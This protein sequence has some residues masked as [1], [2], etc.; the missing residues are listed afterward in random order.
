MSDVMPS[1]PALVRQQAERLPAKE[2]II[3]GDRRV[4]Y[5]ELERGM[6]ETAAAMVAHGVQPGDRVAIWAP[7]SIDWLLAGLGALATGASIVP[8]SSRYRGGEA[9]DIITRSS[10]KLVLTS[11]AFR[12]LDYPTMLRTECPHLDRVPLVLLAGESSA[13][14][15]L[16][17]QDFLADGG[18]HV[19]EVNARIDALHP[20]D[21]AY[22]LFTSGTTGRP[23]GAL[24]AH[25][26]NLMCA[27]NLSTYWPVTEDDRMYVALPFFHIFGLNGGFLTC[28]TAGATCVIASVFE[29]ETTLQ[30]MERER[31]TFVPGP[32]TIFQG[33]LDHPDRSNYDLSSLKRGFV[34]ST[35]VSETLLRRMLD[36]G[37]VTAIGTGYGLTEAGGTVTLSPPDDDPEITARWSGKILPTVE[38]RIVDD[39]GRDLSNGQEGEILVRSRQVMH[40]YLD[41][42]EATALAID[43]DGW[44]HTGDV[45]SVNDDGY[46]KVTDRKKDMFIV[47][48]FNAYPAEIE[49]IL[50]RHSHVKSVAVVG[51]PDERL[52]EVGVAFVIPPPGVTP[53][54]DEI[55]AFAREQ[56][57]NFKVPRY[58]E[59]VDALPMTPSSK[60]RKDILRGQAESAGHAVTH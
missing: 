32:P 1:I 41:D 55:I 56:M 49:A 51:A 38:V 36:D 29:I 47:G 44:L 42:P 34:A 15:T 27:Q 58:V 13:E 28:V 19:N 59:F 52:G 4:T 5:A 50:S 6:L 39:E 30:V 17:W 21:V 33:I 8:V 48:G 18:H 45:G 9:G 37:L 2:A 23:K 57:A 26:H 40:G 54:A 43:G 22:V 12:G 10:A 11:G 31:I 16:G 35:M 25:S 14:G 7:N 53:S 60:V 3:D 24:M 46:L 20:D